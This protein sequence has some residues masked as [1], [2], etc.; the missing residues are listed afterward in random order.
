MGSGLLNNLIELH[1]LAAL[2]TILCSAVFAISS[3]F[4]TARDLYDAVDGNL[5]LPPVSM[6]IVV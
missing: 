6:M 3:A 2:Q 1:S 4:L 5:P